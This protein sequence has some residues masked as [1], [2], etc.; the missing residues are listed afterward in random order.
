MKDDRKNLKICPQL[1]KQ[2]KTIAAKNGITMVELLQL[3]ANQEMENET[4]D[5]GIHGSGKRAHSV[6]Y[7]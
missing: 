5:N 6:R 7:S 4:N 2:I 3:W 1:H